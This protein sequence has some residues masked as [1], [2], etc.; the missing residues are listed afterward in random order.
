MSLPVSP[1]GLDLFQL[2]PAVYRVRDMQLAQSLPLLTAE[3]LATLTQLQLLSQPGM[4]ALA[5]PSVF[6]SEPVRMAGRVPGPELAT[7]SRATSGAAR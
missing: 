5:P 2:L 3:E 4:Q 6:S 1:A 7:E